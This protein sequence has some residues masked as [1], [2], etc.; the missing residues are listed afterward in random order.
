MSQLHF[1]EFDPAIHVL[2]RRAEALRPDLRDLR[3]WGGHFSQEDI[4][5]RDGLGR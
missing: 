4:E 3:G 2:E 5:R 1:L